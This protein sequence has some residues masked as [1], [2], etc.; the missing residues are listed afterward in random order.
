MRAMIVSLKST[1][2]PDGGR[3]LQCTLLG[4]V[5]FAAGV[6]IYL[7][8]FY[9][10]VPNI[11]GLPEIP[12]VG[13]LH[14]HLHRLGDDHA[15]TAERWAEQHNWPVYQV[16]MGNRRAIILNSFDS[17]HAFLVKNQASTID[18]PVFYTFHRVVSKTSGVYCCILKML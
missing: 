16:R 10:D 8:Y 13:L 2:Q 9:V 4:S 18:R 15:T 5:L 14:G 6:L 3:L 1:L 7:A 12:H 11:R 17:A